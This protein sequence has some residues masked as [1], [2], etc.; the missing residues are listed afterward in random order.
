MNKLGKIPKGVNKQFAA[1]DRTKMFGAGDRTRSKVSAE[2]QRPGRNR[3][4]AHL[5]QSANRKS[6]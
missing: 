2:P 6:L 4:T 5:H 3:R 1:G